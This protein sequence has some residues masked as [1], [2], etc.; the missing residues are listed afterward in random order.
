MASG[1]SRRKSPRTKQQPDTPPSHDHRGERMPW[2]VAGIAVF[3]LLAIG[4]SSVV[5]QIGRNHLKSGFQKDIQSQVNANKKTAED[6]RKLAART[7]A[8]EKRLEQLVKSVA[9]ETCNF[10]QNSKSC[11]ALKEFIKSSDDAQSRQTHSTRP[12]SSG[13]Q[14]APTPQATPSPRASPSERPSPRPGPSPTHSPPPVVQVCTPDL[15]LV[16]GRCVRALSITA[17]T[18]PRVTAT[19]P[20]SNDEGGLPVGALSAGAIALLAASFVSPVVGWLNRLFSREKWSPK[21]L[22]VIAYVLAALGAAL[23]DVTLL[24][25]Q[26]WQYYVL[27]IGL[28]FMMHVATHKGYSNLGVTTAPPASDSDAGAGGEGPPEQV[29]ARRGTTKAKR[30]V[31][32]EAGVLDLLLAIAVVLLLFAIFGGVFIGHALF[33]IL[34]LAL[35][36]FVVAAARRS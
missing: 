35:I 14:P 2:W 8:N 25:Q 10:D 21:V 11:K 5:D 22:S 16:S 3:V 17:F 1:Q 19:D 30:R 28:A 18:P 23:S 13:P 24:D 36:L 33:W 9:G 32:G 29:S 20:T 6:A 27:T 15:I 26:K 31:S 12:S 34:V 4:G 7:D